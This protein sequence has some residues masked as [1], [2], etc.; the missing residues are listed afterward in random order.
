MW[1]AA[2]AIAV[3]GEAFEIH[4]EGAID[5][6]NKNPVILDQVLTADAS[7][8]GV[9]IAKADTVA[10]GDAPVLDFGKV[11]TDAASA[12]EAVSFAASKVFTDSASAVEAA[13]LS[14]GMNPVDTS[15]TSDSLT[16]VVS[17]VLTD[18]AASTAAANWWKEDYVAWDYFAGDYIANATGTF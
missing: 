8:F 17:K 3:N 13:V 2:Y 16:N 9:S 18:S 7:A 6:A 15:T 12:A 14:Y 11:F 4:V 5:Y 1:S 10:A